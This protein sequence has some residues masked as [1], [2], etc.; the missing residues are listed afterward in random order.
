MPLKNEWQEGIQPK[1]W[2]LE[3]CNNEKKAKV[4]AKVSP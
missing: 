3:N 4:G 1:L 2:C